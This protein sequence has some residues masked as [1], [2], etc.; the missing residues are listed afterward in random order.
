MEIDDDAELEFDLDLDL[1]LSELSDEE[2]EQELTIAAGNEHRDE[3]FRD[4]LA[5]RTRRRLD[6]EL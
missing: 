6:G 2:I 1:D 4:L 5:E 3:L